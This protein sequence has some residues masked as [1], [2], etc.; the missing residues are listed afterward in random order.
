MET[1][2]DNEC[3]GRQAEDAFVCDHDSNT[4]AAVVTGTIHSNQGP[5]CLSSLHQIGWSPAWQNAFARHSDAATGS[6]AARVSREHCGAYTVITEAGERSAEVSGHFRHTA[7]ARSDFPAVGDWVV[8]QVPDARSTCVIHAILPRLSAFVRKGAGRT[9]EE[10]VIAANIDTAFLVSGLDHNFNPRRIERY[11]TLAHESG[12]DPVILLNKSDCATDLDGV[13]HETESIA[14][15][16]PVLLVSAKQRIG[17]DEVRGFLKPGTTG[18]LLGSS[19]VG[20][21]SLINALLGVERLRTAAVREHD[22]RGRH[23]TSSRHLIPLPNGAV[24]IDTPGM[25]ELQLMAGEETVNRVFDEIAEWAG[26][27]RFHDCAHTGEPGCA[28]QAALETGELCRERYESYLRQRKE[29]R[30]HQIESDIHLKIAEQK[31]WKAIYKSM[32]YHI[33]NRQDS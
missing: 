12:A 14:Y 26:S 24:L 2:N 9:P 19:G 1:L 28:V 10:Q 21:S 6:V 18:V 5:D 4:A 13:L 17:L 8:L 27:C 15:G 31:R 7:Q 16:I 29:I 25:R 20:K 30:H 33:K 22:S 32:R 3:A 11:I 23:T